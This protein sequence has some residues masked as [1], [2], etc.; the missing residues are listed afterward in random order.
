MMFLE[1]SQYSPQTPE[2]PPQFYR[3]EHPE[4]EDVPILVDPTI[5]PV[6]YEMDQSGPNHMENVLNEQGDDTNNE[7]TFEKVGVEV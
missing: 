7:N 4:E 1:S 3:D 5:V 6:T 2:Y